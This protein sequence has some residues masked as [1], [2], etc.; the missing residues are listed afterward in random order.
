MKRLLI[1]IMVL[2]MAATAQAQL[3]DVVLNDEV[4]KHN[5][6]EPKHSGYWNMTPAQHAMFFEY[7]VEYIGEPQKGY[8]FTGTSWVGIVDMKSRWQRFYAIDVPVEPEVPEPDAEKIALKALL[9]ALG[10]DASLSKA[11]QDAAKAAATATKTKTNTTVT[12]ISD[13]SK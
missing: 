12:A 8:H 6:G 3:W 9:D 5:V 13:V 10:K 1:A 4:I 7:M 2:T 11:T